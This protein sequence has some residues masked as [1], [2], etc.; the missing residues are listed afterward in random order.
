MTI[1]LLAAEEFIIL[2][3]KLLFLLIIFPQCYGHQFTGKKKN[4]ALQLRLR[5][6]PEAKSIKKKKKKTNKP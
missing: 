6:M 5:S 2:L 4:K 3:L 1:T